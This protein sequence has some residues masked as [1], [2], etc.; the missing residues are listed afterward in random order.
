VKERGER[1]WVR[2]GGKEGWW[3]VIMKGIVILKTLG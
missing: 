1:V 3:M 2:L